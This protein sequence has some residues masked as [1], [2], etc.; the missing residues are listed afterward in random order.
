M[1]GK[2]WERYLS[3]LRVFFPR[4]GTRHGEATAPSHSV[5]GPERQ[6]LDAAPADEAIS[7]PDTAPAD[8]AAS[9]P[10][11]A[12]IL[13]WWALPPGAAKPPARDKKP[14]APAVPFPGFPEADKPSSARGA[15]SAQPG[16][17]ECR[18]CKKFL[19]SNPAWLGP[20]LFHAP[21]PPRPQNGQQVIP[22]IQKEMTAMMSDETLP[23]D[24]AM[25]DGSPA[26]E[27]YSEPAPPDAPDEP[28]AD[29]TVQSEA[30][31]PA[32]TAAV[33]PLRVP[34]TT[35][36]EHVPWTSSRVSRGISPRYWEKP[37]R[38]R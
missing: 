2:R 32:S 17:P 34:W 25:P 11:A 1:R 20:G 19:L 37:V 24:D 36:R 18:S 3:L 7:P 13:P 35:V 21:A 14:G 23:Q 26:A 9:R 22:R 27:D 29:P 28:E 6:G 4:F 8:E 30:Q 5:T 33:P 12:P 31:P 15:A 10:D 38:A 16:D